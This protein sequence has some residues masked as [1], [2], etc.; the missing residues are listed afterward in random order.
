MRQMRT[1][2]IAAQVDF[3]APSTV[4]GGR[5]R[6]KWEIPARVASVERSRGWKAGDIMS[7]QELELAYEDLKVRG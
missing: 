7:I 1:G 5:I 6:R 4:Q 2:C 3:T